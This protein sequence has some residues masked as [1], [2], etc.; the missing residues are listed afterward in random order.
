MSKGEQSETA[1]RGDD[2]SEIAGAENAAGGTAGGSVAGAP[3]GGRPNADVDET[4]A[5]SFPASDP[6]A[7]SSLR[8][9]APKRPL[10]ADASSSPR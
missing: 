4:S 1:S 2:R 3:T 7:W 8:V 5:E 10:T 9:G 6:P